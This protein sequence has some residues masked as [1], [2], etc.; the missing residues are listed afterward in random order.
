MD[1]T[2]L[3]SYSLR[4]GVLISAA[5]SVVGLGVWLADGGNALAIVSGSQIVNSILGALQTNQASGLIYLAVVVLVATPI[6][7]VA[8][9]AVYFSHARDGKFVL[10]SLVVLS[11]LFLALLSGS[12]G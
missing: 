4:I 10:I 6:F 3:I 8:L 11:M 1:I 5:L 2:R 7:R 9:T 12:T